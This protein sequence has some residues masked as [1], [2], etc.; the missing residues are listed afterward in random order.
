MWITPWLASRVFVF[1]RM[2]FTAFR[3]LSFFLISLVSAAPAELASRSLIQV[4]NLTNGPPHCTNSPGWIGPAFNRHD[5][6]DALNNFLVANVTEFE[7]TEFEFLAPGA[8]PMHAIPVVQ[9]PMKVT[10]G[11]CTLVIAMLSSF[12]PGTLP[13]VGPQAYPLTDPSSFRDI[14]FTALGLSVQCTRRQRRPGWSRT[15]GRQAVGVFFWG[16]ESRI[17]M[18]VRDRIALIRPSQLDVLERDDISSAE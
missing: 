15:G 13:G 8:F 17:N 6:D 11:T 18:Q 5:C 7:G 14:Y 4:H 10:S 1:N 12:I 9:T 16:T 3:I 2:S